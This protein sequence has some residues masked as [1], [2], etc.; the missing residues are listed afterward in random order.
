LEQ[1]P[2]YWNPLGR[3]IFATFNSTYLQHFED[4]RDAKQTQQEYED[5]VQEVKRSVPAEKLLVY[6]VSQGFAPLCHFLGVAEPPAGIPFPHVQDNWVEIVVLVELA[7]YLTLVVPL[8]AFV[9][10]A[11]M[12]LQHG[13]GRNP[14]QSLDQYRASD[15]QADTSLK[16]AKRPKAD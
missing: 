10:F 3:S 16:R 12:V 1:F 2:F 9:C 8:L 14:P 11:V 4:V 13:A 7:G 6:N 5:W 15:G